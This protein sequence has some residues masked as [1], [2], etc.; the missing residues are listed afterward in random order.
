M[1]LEKMMKSNLN[2]TEQQ[3][4]VE[5]VNIFT[6]KKKKPGFDYS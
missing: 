6:T 5:T 3:S 2:K 4:I 1:T